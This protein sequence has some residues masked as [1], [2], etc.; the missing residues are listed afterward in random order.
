MTHYLALHFTCTLTSKGQITI[1]KAIRERLGIAAGDKLK[2]TVTPKDEIVFTP[3][4]SWTTPAHQLSSSRCGPTDLGMTSYSRH[5]KPVYLSEQALK[6]LR[7]GR[8][9]SCG[10]RKA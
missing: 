6:E 7:G 9:R 8:E 10:I 3:R 2:V 5:R 4:K 1:P